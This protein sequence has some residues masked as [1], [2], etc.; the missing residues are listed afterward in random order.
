MA[1]DEYGTVIGTGR[2]ILTQPIP[3]VGRMAVLQAWRRHGVGAAV[4]E[5]LCD[6]ARQRGYQQVL[7]HA[8]THATAFYFQHGFLSHGAEFIEAGIPHQ[9]MRRDLAE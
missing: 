8:Q 9:E 6:E 2:L 1:C 5:K 3:R 7:L 4:L